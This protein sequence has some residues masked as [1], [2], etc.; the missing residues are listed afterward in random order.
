MKNTIISKTILRIVGIIAIIAVIG[1]TMTACSPDGGPT[2]GTVEYKGTANG[3]TYTLKITENTGR[4]AYTPKAG[5]KYELTVDTK[6][7]TGTVESYSNNTFKLKPSN[8]G[9]E[10]FNVTVSP[11]G[12]TEISG[13]ITFDDKS[14]D[15]SAK[16]APITVQPP[17]TGDNNNG[18]GNSNE[19]GNNEDLWSKY[20]E[21]DSTAT[22]DFSVDKD[23]VCKII[24]SG[25]PEP[26]DWENGWEAWKAR[27]IY[28]FTAKAGK[29]YMYKFEAWTESGTRDLKIQYYDDAYTDDGDG[30]CYISETIPITSTRT[31]YTV[32][33][34][35]IP[36][37]WSQVAFH[38]AH[39]IGTY[40]IKMIEITELNIGR[41]TITN[42]SG[43]NGIT[44]N[45]YVNGS[46]VNDGLYFFAH[47]V[48]Y[49]NYLDSKEGITLLIWYSQ[50]KGDTI[51]L[52]VWVVNIY[53]A[54]K[55]TFVPFTGTKIIGIGDLIIYELDEWWGR[56]EY[57]NIVPITLTNGN[58]TIDFETQMKEY[59][60]P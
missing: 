21:E 32:Y 39:C 10:T 19:Q 50:V 54:D 20:V 26:N 27:V 22:L 15:D 5:D 57:T 47:T 31:T 7:S 59:V 34:Q 6:K 48:D 46:F 9:A 3:K 14:I 41:L 35:T 25:T 24:V 43:A 49:A 23:G 12:I 18:S 17:S 38:S 33:G 1:L 56:K 16:N 36:K 45:N 11:S 2:P 13:T 51:I 30:T 4:A 53:D 8:A 52:P 55:Y 58:A 28:N 40:Y 44:Q 42:F 37:E 29:N 60:E